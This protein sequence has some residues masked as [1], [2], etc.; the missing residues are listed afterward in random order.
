[1][2][3]RM[4]LAGGKTAL[5]VM[6]FLVLV[7]CTPEKAKS[8]R[9]DA[10]PGRDVVEKDGFDPFKRRGERFFRNVSGDLPLPARC[11]AA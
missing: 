10:R 5:L 6:V 11:D 2:N 7:G 1:M 9:L 4:R 3:E 8:L